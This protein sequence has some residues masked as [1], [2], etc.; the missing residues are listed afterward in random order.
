MTE[1]ISFAPFDSWAEL[2]EH[3]NKLQVHYKCP[4]DFYPSLV[5]V[6][7]QFKNGKLRIKAAHNGVAFTVDKDHLS[8]FFKK[9]RP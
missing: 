2:L 7:K 3:V 9:N 6:L 4:L 1:Q 8:R 5:I